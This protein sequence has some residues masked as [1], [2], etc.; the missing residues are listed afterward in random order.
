VVRLALIALSF[1]SLSPRAF[2]CSCVPSGEC[3]GLGNKA[4]PVF[5]GTVLSVTDLPRTGDDAFLSTRRARI[6]V[7]ESFGGLSPDMHEVDVLTGNGGGDCGVPFRAG[8]MYLIGASVGPDGLVHAGICGITR[9]IEAA[10]VALRVLRQRRDGVRAPSLTGQIAQVDRNFEGPLGMHAPKPLADIRVRVKSDGT[11]YE[12]RADGYGLYEFYNLPSGK[13]EFAPDL[14]PGT[15]LSWFIDSDAPQT[16]FELRAGAC[17]ERNIEVFASGSIQGRILGSSNK[18]LPQAFA[19]IVPADKTVLPKEN[20]L[21]WRSQDKEGFFKFVH[22]PPGEYL[23]VV[24]P[25]DSE[26]PAFPYRRTFYP[27]AHD[28]ASARI[29]TVHGGEQIKDVDIRLEQQFTPRHLSVRVVWSDGRLIKD[30]VFVQAEGT[31]NAA[32]MS[33]ATQPD[34]K[35]SVLDLSVL[36]NES[37]EVEAELTCRYR[38]E[39]SEG[40]GAR[41][42][43]NKFHLE[44]KDQRTEVILTMPATACPE[45]SGKTLVTDQ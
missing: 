23:I 8:E 40:P 7:D 30:F 41:L 45:I 42:K 21:Y 18:L 38:D 3:P 4:F 28:R 39:R 14:P 34:L 13:Y 37:Y 32:A 9:R 35:A 5:V 31:A 20:E 36:P 25:D 24:N 1:L 10:G 19:Y 11:V 27:G 33:D 2:S 29:I 16:P 22:I 15:T 26:N 6:Q 44:P 12:T 43:S 17:Q